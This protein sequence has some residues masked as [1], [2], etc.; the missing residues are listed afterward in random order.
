MELSA[1]G[2]NLDVTA[3]DKCVCHMKD[4]VFSTD[5]LV[6]THWQQMEEILLHL[7]KTIVVVLCCQSTSEVHHNSRNGTDVR[8]TSAA[9]FTASIEKFLGALYTK[10]RLINDVLLYPVGDQL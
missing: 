4:D 3:G 1:F 2:Q 5:C 10:T 7:P 8:D 9:S 6:L